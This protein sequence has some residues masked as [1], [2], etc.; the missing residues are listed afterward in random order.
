MDPIKRDR[1]LEL[2]R[3]GKKNRDARWMGVAIVG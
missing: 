3:S 2:T 1:G